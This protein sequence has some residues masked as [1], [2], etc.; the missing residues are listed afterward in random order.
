MG[1][2]ASKED[3]QPKAEQQVPAVEPEDDEPDEW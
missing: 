1:A 3:T 2:A